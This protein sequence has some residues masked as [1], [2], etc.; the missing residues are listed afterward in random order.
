MVNLQFVRTSSRSKQWEW[1]AMGALVSNSE[2]VSVRNFS[3]T[4][5]IH[6][7]PYRRQPVPSGAAGTLRRNVPALFPGGGKVGR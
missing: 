3:P 4:Q 2:A 1:E 5:L 6:L 7:T